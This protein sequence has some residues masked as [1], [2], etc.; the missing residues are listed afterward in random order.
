MLALAALALVRRERVGL[1][2][3]LAAMLV[4]HKALWPFAA[5]FALVAR[6]RGHFRGRRVLLAGAPLA[7]LWAYG[8]R[9]GDV[10]WLVTRDVAHM[11]AP[12][13]GFP[14]LDG[15]L[16]TFAAGGPR[17]L[18]KGVLVALTTVGAGALSVHHARR[19][20]LDLA[21]L[22][23]P[24]ALLGLALNPWEIWATVR[25]GRALV[26]PAAA[27]LATAPWAARLASSVRAR[28][29]VVVALVGAQHAVAARVEATFRPSAQASTRPAP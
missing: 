14:V 6:V 23:A 24:V 4:V 1:A 12:R 28:S 27:V 9:H 13:A 17:G 7:L 20:R 15:V 2:L 18:V 3:A 29:L 11:V 21:A 26:F 10:G 5:A 8:A 16:G 25:F 22:A 19:G